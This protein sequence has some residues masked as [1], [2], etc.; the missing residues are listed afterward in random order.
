[1][2][3]KT[4][5]GADFRRPAGDMGRAPRFVAMAR[6]D[7]FALTTYHRPSRPRP[8]AMVAVGLDFATTGRWTPDATLRGGLRRPC[9]TRRCGHDS[10][11]SY[12]MK[13]THAAPSIAGTLWNENPAAATLAPDRNPRGLARGAARGTPAAWRATQFDPADPEMNG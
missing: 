8:A 6:R 2:S 4:V 11:V 7:A 5:A 10:A 3:Y 1:M 13:P 12:L 9:S